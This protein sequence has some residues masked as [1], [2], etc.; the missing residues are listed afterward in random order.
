MI[1]GRLNRLPF[2]SLNYLGLSSRRRRAR[3]ATAHAIALPGTITTLRENG[4]TGNRRR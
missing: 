3:K 2:S 1:Y 4:K